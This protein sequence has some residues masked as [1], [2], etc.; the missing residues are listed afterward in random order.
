SRSCSSPTTERMAERAVAL[1]GALA[2]PAP[3]P[4][5]SAPPQRSFV[6][7]RVVARRAVRTGAI[8]GYIFGAYVAAQ[9]YTY[10]STYKTEV[11][12]E[13]LAQL[14]GGN[15]AI[16][17]LVG[18]ARHIETVAGFTAWKSLAVLSITA[19]V[20]GLLMSTRL[21]RGEE[22]TGRLELL[23]AGDTT[24]RGAALQALAGLLA[25]VVVSLLLTGAIVAIAGLSS[26]IRFGV[27]DS[28]YLALTIA[29]AMAMFVAVGVLTSQLF[30]TRRQASTAG[31]A[32]L[33][34]AYALR[35]VADSGTGLDWMRLTSPLG[36][37]EQLQPLTA[38]RPVALLPIAAFTLAC[39]SAAVLL[40][41]R[42]DLLGSTFADR[43]TARAR[44]RSLGSAPALALRLS[45]GSLVAWAVGAAALCLLLGYVAKPAGVALASSASIE[46]VLARL[47]A[48]GNG[49][50]AY[51]VVGYLLLA[52]MVAFVAAGQ[53]AAIRAE[54]E[55]GRVESLLTRSVSRASW[56][57]WRIAVATGIVVA[58]AFAGGVAMW[59]GC[60]GGGAAVGFGTLLESAAAVVPP[61]LCVVGLGCLGIGAWPRV[62]TWGAYA[63]VGWAFLVEI[64]G[65]SVDV[66]HFVL[67]TS[68]LHQ[69]AA[70]PIRSPDWVSSGLLLALGL[71][72]DIVGVVA[73]TRRDLAGE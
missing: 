52:T 42:R 65:S 19:A 4:P 58:V 37:I 39:S 59:L 29:S 73:F 40:A 63:L 41:S 27:G 35:M 71:A 46:H 34:A 33:G 5:A 2:P 72:A 62:A 44:L 10:A 16:D 47:G 68:V 66:N 43:S 53:V 22:D 64:F 12:R 32:V 6:V 1:E 54:E 50:R 70:V 31:A 61:A 55:S 51:L 9:A 7:G 49:A 26:R 24:R 60:A 57:S 48:G 3:A 38:P 13:R 45:R 20:V 69:M 67:D 36:W 28:A 14:F 18:P 11:S 25:A 15:A 21:T 17:A 30:A 23:L 8:W 56:L